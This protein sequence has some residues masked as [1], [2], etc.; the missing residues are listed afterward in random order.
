MQA[1]K[2]RAYV[3]AAGAATAALAIYAFAA[4]ITVSH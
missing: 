2:E 1:L 4:P 3:V